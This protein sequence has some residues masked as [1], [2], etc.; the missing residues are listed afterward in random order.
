MYEIQEKRRDRPISPE[1][2]A[3][4]DGIRPRLKKE[5][6]ERGYDAV[7]GS[8][9]SYARRNDMRCWAGGS[10]SKQ[11]IGARSSIEILFRLKAVSTDNRFSTGHCVGWVL[12]I[13]EGYLN[14]LA[15][16]RERLFGGR[17]NGRHPHEERTEERALAII[18]Q[19][20]AEE[21]EEIVIEQEPQSLSAALLDA[22]LAG[23]DEAIMRI[24]VA[25]EALERSAK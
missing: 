8:L 4:E 25:V 7:A 24:A 6:E 20:V 22:Y 19:P 1:R 14:D 5:V 10:Y 11:K 18:E 15:S 3:R 2:Q 16:E 21:E 17:V 13:M 12:D 9:V 23:D